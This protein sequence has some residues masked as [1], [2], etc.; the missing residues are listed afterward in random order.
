MS[1][2]PGRVENGRLWLSNLGLGSEVSGGKGL[3]IPALFL[4]SLTDMK[5]EAQIVVRA[6]VQSPERKESP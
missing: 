6:S 3:W 5:G 4:L 2:I 1:R